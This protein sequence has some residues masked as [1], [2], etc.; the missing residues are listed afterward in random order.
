MNDKKLRP[1]SYIV[2]FW[3]EDG[4]KMLREEVYPMHKYSFDDVTDKVSGIEETCDIY[5]GRY[6]K[7]R[8]RY[9]TTGK[10]YIWES[11]Q[12]KVQM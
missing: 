5:E 3:N 11:G 4:T 6:L 9:I 7:E 8:G 1:T 2:L 10:T 12:W